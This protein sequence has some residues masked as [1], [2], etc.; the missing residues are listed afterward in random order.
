MGGETGGL[1]N[2]AAGHFRTVSVRFCK[3]V[4]DYAGADWTDFQS[5]LRRSLAHLVAVAY[6]LPLVEPSS[7][8]CHSIPLQ[9]WQQ[10]YGRLK[11]RLEVQEYWLVFSPLDHNDHEPVCA[12]L[13]D[14]LADIWRDLQSGLLATDPD[15]A[16]WRWRFSFHSHWGSHATAALACLQRASNESSDDKRR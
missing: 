6:A 1:V 10:L 5:E 11:E 9:R 16:V 15:D 2:D 3:L 7:T 12:D 14:D 13:A 4:E 8:E